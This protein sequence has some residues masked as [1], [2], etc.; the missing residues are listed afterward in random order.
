MRV[1]NTY[2][3][4]NVN[5]EQLQVSQFE[6]MVHSA[7][8]RDEFDKFQDAGDAKESEN[9]DNANNAGIVVG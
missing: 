8:S 1:S 3:S 7:I 2:A 6:F 9:L 5:C 4:I